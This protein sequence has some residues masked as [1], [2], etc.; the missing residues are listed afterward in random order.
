[1]SA[2]AIPTSGSFAFPGSNFESEGGTPVVRST[3]NVPALPAGAV[4]TGAELRLFNAVA[5]SPSW[6]S[7]IRVSLGGDYVL[8]VTGPL[9]TSCSSSGT[10]S[11][12]PVVPLPGYA[13]TGASTIDLLLNE[14]FNDGVNPDGIVGS[15]ELV[16][17]YDVVPSLTWYDAPT[18]GTNWGSG[19][20][21]DPVTAGAVDANVGGTYPFYVEAMLDGCPSTREAA[22]FYVGNNDLTL[23][24]ETDGAGSE[25]TW[26]IVQQ[27]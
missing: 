27:G 7:E 22:Y 25:T 6:R 15:V 24:T 11:P 12:D 23:T 2:T 5:N 9:C 3:L 21:F 4:V 18:G 8:P 19:S 16:V 14:S 26:E 13:L 20:P 17:F 10:I 1:A